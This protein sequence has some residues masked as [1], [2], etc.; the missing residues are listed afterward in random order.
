MTVIMTTKRNCLLT[1]ILWILKTSVKPITSNYKKVSYKEIHKAIE[2]LKD[3]VRLNK[4]TAIQNM[5]PPVT[6]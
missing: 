4:H 1:R 5:L 2:Q 3:K 6:F